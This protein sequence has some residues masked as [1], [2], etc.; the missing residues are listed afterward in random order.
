MNSGLPGEL[1]PPYPGV[2]RGL[3]RG[4]CER[5]LRLWYVVRAAETPRRL[6]V[7]AVLVVLYF[8]FPFDLVSDLLPL[9]GLSDDLLGLAALAFALNRHVTPPIR[10]RARARALSLIP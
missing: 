7:A 6:K 9:L 5:C 10:Q 2:F 8:L 3:L 4:V 1:P